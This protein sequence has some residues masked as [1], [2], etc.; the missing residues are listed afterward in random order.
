MVDWLKESSR[1]LSEKKEILREIAETANTLQRKRIESV[2][3]EMD[4]LIARIEEKGETNVD[5][6]DRIDLLLKTFSTMIVGDSVGEILRSA[7]E[8]AAK[9]TGANYGAII[10]KT[11]FESSSIP[12]VCYPRG[13]TEPYPYSRTIVSDVINTGKSIFVTDIFTDKKYSDTMSIQAKRIVSILAAPIQSFGETIGV[14]Y[15]DSR[16]SARDFNKDDLGFLQNFASIVSLALESDIRRE[17]RIEYLEKARATNYKGLIGKSG[18]FMKILELIDKYAPLKQPVLILGESGTGKRLVAEELHRRSN[19]KGPFVD[20]NCSNIP[21]TLIESELFGYRRGAF[22]GAFENREGYIS[23]AQDGTLFL[24][25]IGD[26][27]PGTQAKILQFLDNQTYRILGESRN[28]QTSNTRVITA[29]NK[30]LL[31]L[32]DEGEF[33]EDLYYRLNNLIIELPPLRQRIDDIPELCR[34][35]TE[36]SCRELNKNLLGIEDAVIER[37][38]RMHWKGNVREL[39]HFI[40]RLVIHAD[41]A[42]ISLE[43]FDK[44]SGKHEEAVDVFQLLEGVKEK[45]II[46]NVRK[47]AIEKANGNL[48]QAAEILDISPSTLSK[49]LK[50]GIPPRSSK[51]DK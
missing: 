29:T 6:G 41:G 19:R 50:R 4:K 49:W 1:R 31:K 10:L 45:E 16:E 30:D 28:M 34:H 47:K 13:C 42:S 44:L 33:R 21:E 18:V 23:V 35:F 36:V 11:E 7:L 26:L 2:I 51:F 32:I 48:K 40:E 5:G 15:L 22:T 37:M 20:V 27:K 8:G 17:R 39:K 14:V 12:M 25:E 46:E 43:L 3:H 38:K 9:L 24:D